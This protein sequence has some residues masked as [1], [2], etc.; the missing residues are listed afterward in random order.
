MT[1]TRYIRPVNRVEHTRLIYTTSASMPRS[2]RLPDRASPPKDNELATGLTVP[3]LPPNRSDRPMQSRSRNYA[4]HDCTRPV[5]A[6]RRTRL[7]CAPE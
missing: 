7:S 6:H 3:N 5:S 1:C 2:Y 4:G